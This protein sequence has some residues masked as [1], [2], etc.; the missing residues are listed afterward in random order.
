MD[1]QKR[2]RGKIEGGKRMRRRVKEA[3]ERVIKRERQRG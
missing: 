1:R 2:N 3:A